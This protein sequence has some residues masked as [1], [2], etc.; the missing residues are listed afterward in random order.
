MVWLRREWRLQIQ[1]RKFECGSR[2]IS[3]RMHVVVLKA[4]DPATSLVCLIFINEVVRYR[5]SNPMLTRSVQP[6][7]EI[8]WKG[9]TETPSKSSLFSFWECQAPVILILF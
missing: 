2:L 8:S 6:A 1:R 7:K 5:V 9:E 3:C 4:I